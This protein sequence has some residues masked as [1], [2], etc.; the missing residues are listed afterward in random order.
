MQVLFDLFSPCVPGSESSLDWYHFVAD[1]G[2]IGALEMEFFTPERDVA[3]EPILGLLADKLMHHH[4]LSLDRISSQ[5]NV[6][7]FEI[8]VAYEVLKLIFRA[9]Q[10]AP[11]LFDFDF[12]LSWI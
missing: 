4:S 6:T 11:R 2:N 9:K 5:A 7:S 1:E 3:G 8:T 12:R 10:S